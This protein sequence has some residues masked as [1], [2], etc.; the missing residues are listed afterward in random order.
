MLFGL[1]VDGNA[2]CGPI[3]PQGWR[4]VAEAVIGLRPP[5]TAQDGK[6]RRTTGVSSAWFSAHFRQCP[7]DADEGLVQRYA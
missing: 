3:Q 7:V 2:V 6:D 5:E 1:P 4:D